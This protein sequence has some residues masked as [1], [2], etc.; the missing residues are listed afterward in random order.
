MRSAAVRKTEGG[1]VC[2][3]LALAVLAVFG[4]TTH[5]EF[6]NYDDDKNVYQNPVVE[7]GLSMQA[8]GWAF[9]HPQ[10]ANWIPLTTLSHML[11]CQ[12]F[13][14]HAGGHHLV[15]VLLHAATAV[16][17]FLVLRRM[18]GSLWRSAFV[19]AVFA[20]HPLRAESVAWVSERKDVLSALFFMLTLGAYVR[21]T[22]KPSWTGHVAVILLFT[23]G[24]LSKSMV[25][26]LPFVLLLLD[27]WPLKR[28]ADCGLRIEEWKPL[29]I[30]KIPL[31][32]LA[33][34]A[35][36]ATA[37]MPD[38]QVILTNT[39]RLPLLERIGNAL[40]SY[41]VYLRQMAF[42]AGQATPYPILPNGQ[43]PWNVC[44]AFVVLAAIS[45][46]V[47]ACRKK[48]PWL[49]TGWL[50]YV[51]M[52]VPVIGIIQISPDAAHAN[53]YTYLPEIGL[54]LAGTWAV[55]DWSAGWKQRRVILGGLM[56]IIIGALAICGHAQTSYWKNGETLWTRALD[57]TSD[58]SVAHNNIGY[59][60]YQ[61]GKVED[62][63]RHYKQALEINPNYAQAHF[64]LGVIFLKQGELDD[65]IAE[66]KQA[67]K[68]DP[69]YME[70]HFDL[71]SALALKG[72]LDEAIAQYRKVLEIRPEYA[73]ADYNLGRVLLLKGD[74]NEAMAHL[75]KTNAGSP[76]SLARW[77][78]LGNE[79]LQERDWACAIVCYR[80][81]IKINP[82]SADAYANL[83]VALSQK[84]ETKE[85]MDSWQTAL[86]INPD[87][88]YVQ[89]NLAWLL[90]TAPDAALR[91]G[92][93]A[94]ALAQ[95]AS[96]SSGGEN[97]FILQTLA[98]AY[99]EKGSYETAVATARRALDLAATQKAGALIAALQTEIKLYETNTPVR[100]VS[101]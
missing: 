52:L 96:Q 97:P 65:A 67:L 99:A 57:C 68:I 89:N 26:T 16:L 66:Y 88:V 17:L 43:P 41:V 74:L 58:N 27:Y 86:E 71:G 91:N 21:N 55:A 31:F 24:L 61:K 79:L 75:D 34:A 6:V 4:Q 11:D 15:N 49:L 42:P 37:L 62:A 64:N 40:V 95:R 13:G 36:V 1:A 30:E 19:A 22:R 32:V 98:A 23:L 83:G 9:T 70:A 93:K 35:C 59:A 25:A 51:G 20:V 87:Q 3:F 45:A 69:D 47:V 28:I 33:T 101:R 78:N 54:A 56:A 60:L 38:M 76:D 29:L 72:N 7:K 14:L 85:A 18:T 46:G 5:F 94:V 100:D 8:A 39:H 73:E 82:R 80:Q 77:Y 92:A 90:A 10:V 48:R 53:R 2:V 44:L 63:I 50:W 12:I 81:A 84:G